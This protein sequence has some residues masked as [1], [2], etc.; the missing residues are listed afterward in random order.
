MKNAVQRDTLKDPIDKSKWYSKTCL[1]NPQE[2]KKKK[3]EKKKKKKAG[4]PN[5][6]GKKK[7]RREPNSSRITPLHRKLLASLHPSVAD[8]WLSFLFQFEIFLGF[9]MMSNFLLTPGHFECYL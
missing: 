6:E 9:D 7:G 3:T 5:R 8:G 1:G 4:G 2:S